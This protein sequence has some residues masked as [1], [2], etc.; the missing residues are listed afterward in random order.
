VGG[1]PLHKD[2]VDEVEELLHDG[3]LP[4]V[5]ISCLHQLAVRLPCTA[6]GTASSH[7]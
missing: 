6:P 5:I 3:V 4:Q 1:W 7:A 2:T